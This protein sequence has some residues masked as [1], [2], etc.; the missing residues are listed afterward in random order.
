MFPIKD[1]NPTVH[2]SIIT[3]ILIGINILTWVFV[4]GLG[5]NPT[6]AQS[7]CEFGIIPGEILGNVRNGAQIPI[8]HGLVCV[9]DGNPNWMTL[10]TSMFMHGSWFHLIGNMWFLA[11]F[12]DNVEDVMG[13]FRFL[14]FYLLCGIFAASAQIFSN[15]L[16]VSPMVGASG[17]IGGVMGAYAILFPRAPVHMLVFFGFFFTRIVVPAFLM[18]GY[19]FIIQIFGSFFSTGAG[20]GVA[21][22][23][24]IGGF[25]AG[26]ALLKLFCNPRRVEECRR[27]RGRTERIVRRY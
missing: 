19:W 27:R 5:F 22:W 15:P 4:Q 26:I 13:S 7:V 23:A 25:V 16:S 10:V 21:F 11:I 12:G 1:E 3:Y 9:L 24:H 18:L 6:L 14:I 8:G 17:S 20:G 2:T